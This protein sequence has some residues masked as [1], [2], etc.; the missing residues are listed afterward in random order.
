MTL[1]L[2]DLGWM[3]SGSTETSLLNR[4]APLVL[5]PP[6]C[7]QPNCFWGSNYY[8]VIPS[9]FLL[10]YLTALPLVYTMNRAKIQE[11]VGITAE[12]KRVLL[13]SCAWF[14]LIY[15]GI[16]LVDHSVLPTNPTYSILS[17]FLIITWGGNFAFG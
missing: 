13:W 11:S 17:L 2:W 10:T 3:Y 16:V 12:F 9:L 1:C 15:I 14:T 7:Q 6:S 8:L 4:T 5:P